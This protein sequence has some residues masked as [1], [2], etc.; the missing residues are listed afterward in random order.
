MS[1]TTI[2]KKFLAVSGNEKVSHL[3]VELYY[4]LGG[5]NYATGGMEARGIKLSVSPVN[6]EEREN[7]VVIESY[8]A[9]SGFKKHLKDMARFN[10]KACDSFVLSETEE[11][12][13]IEVVL[14]H[15]G[16]KLI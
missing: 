4:D 14:N 10:Q 11:K 15:N 6:R 3:K 8:V 12:Q 16:L 7:G 5:P 9:F 13:M 1:K 2:S